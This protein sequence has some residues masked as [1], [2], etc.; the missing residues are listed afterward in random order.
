MT[1]H[2]CSSLGTLL[3]FLAL[4]ATTQTSAAQDRADLTGLWQLSIQESQFGMTR[5]PNSGE[6]EMSQAGTQLVMSSILDFGTDRTR[7]SNLDIPIDGERHTTETEAGD[8]LASAE[9]SRTQAKPSRS[10]EAGGSSARASCTVTV[11][12]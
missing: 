12:Q 2:R 10:S 3:A 11:P 8:G 4:V 6:M 9:S 1:A 5:S 7:E